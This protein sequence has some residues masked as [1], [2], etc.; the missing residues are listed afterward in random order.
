MATQQLSYDFNNALR[1]LDNELATLVSLQPSLISLLTSESGAGLTVLN[2]RTPVTQ[3]K[4]EWPELV[5][6]P[7]QGTVS[8]AHTNV[9]TT[10]TLADG[11]GFVADMM[12]A[13][14]GTDEVMKVTEVA[15]NDLTVVRG[16]GGSTAAALTDGML[17]RVISRPRPEGSDPDPN[18]NAVPRVMY[19]YTEIFD[20]TFK[21][22]GTAV[23]TQLAGVPDLVNTNL[24]QSM[25]RVTRRINAAAIYGRR[26]QRSAS[27]KGSMGGILQLVTN[28]INAAGAALTSTI[29]NDAVETIFKN[30]GAPTAI[31][32]NTNQARKITAFHAAQMFVLRADNTVGSSVNQFQSDLPMGAISNI[33]VEPSYP[34]TKVAL[35]DMSKL[36]LD[37]FAGRGLKEFDATLPG[38]DA[39]SRRLLGEYT[40][41]LLNGGE[42]HAIIDNL[43]V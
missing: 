12:L 1:S 34:K 41:E 37:P 36:Y 17:V 18:A 30:G 24:M 7:E 35:L 3:N 40:L 4:H 21:V 32:C 11:A 16:Y 10:L 5:M 28:R 29:L 9:V 8:G 6:T 27:E 42:A 31:I 33:V 23:N 15:G 22:S 43:A 13:F 26:V 20:D 25:L 38:A 2:S 39:I 14:E 19:N